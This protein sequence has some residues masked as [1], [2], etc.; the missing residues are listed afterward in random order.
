MSVDAYRV[1]PDASWH[2][3]GPSVTLVD[4]DGVVTSHVNDAAVVVT[5]NRVA[6][7][8]RRD[9]VLGTAAVDPSVVT[10]FDATPEADEGFGLRVAMTADG[11]FLFIGADSASDGTDDTGSVV[12]IQR[13]GLDDV[14]GQCIAS[15]RMAGGFRVGWSVTC[16][17]PCC[18]RSRRWFL[19]HRRW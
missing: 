12:F 7:P 18:L 2:V 15:R 4:D 13:D 10:L 5:A 14:A 9:T 19:Q 11:G 6:N 17:V 8:C 16:L 1:R 3:S